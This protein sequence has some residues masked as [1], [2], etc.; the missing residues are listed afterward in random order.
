VVR[1]RTA[2]TLGGS[3]G[4]TLTGPLVRSRLLARDRTGQPSQWIPRRLTLTSLVSTTSA[5]EGSQWGVSFHLHRTRG[6]IWL[7]RAQAVARAQAR[8]LWILLVTMIFYAALLQR[9]S[10]KADFTSLKVPIVDL[11]I[12][13][14]SVLGFGPVLI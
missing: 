1:Q 2:N 4:R 6:L 14:L 9:V 5:Q 12:S 13:G 10:T 11:E 7:S 8:H 3:V